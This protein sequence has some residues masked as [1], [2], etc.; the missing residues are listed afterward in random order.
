MLCGKGE[1]LMD[2]I[3]KMSYG[4]R[5]PWELSRTQCI[6]NVVRKHPICTIVDI[7]AGDC[8]FMSKLADSVS[9]HLY[10]IDTGYTEKTKM[11]MGGSMIHCFNSI[12]ELPELA[13]TA[14][15]M[16]VL[17]HVSND[18][19][20]LKQ[21]TERL[22]ADALVVI[23]VPA[24]QLLFSNHDVFL[25]HYRRYNRKQ[26]LTLLHSNNLIVEKS[27]YFYISLFFARLLSLPLA[28]RKSTL[29]KSGIGNWN[30]NE[31]HILTQAIRVILNIDFKICAFFSRLHINLPGLSLLAICRKQGGPV[32]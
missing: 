12:S 22:S 21:I 20:F 23:T 14:V 18:N 9:G 6:S 31:K 32:V 27:H 17:E 24:F 30:F 13:D 2:L 28:K 3:E 11:L 10:A 29:N 16:D 25:K 5:H 7:G 4:N 26:L 19:V 15:L 1:M 8:F